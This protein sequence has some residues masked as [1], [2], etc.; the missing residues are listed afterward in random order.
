MADRSWKDYGLQLYQTRN[1]TQQKLSQMRQEY[2][3]KIDKEKDAKKRL[4]LI[5]EANKELAHTAVKDYQELIGK[6]ITKEIKKSPLHFRRD[7]D[8]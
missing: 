3:V 1:A 6:L 2:D 8:L 7:P 5:N 4:A